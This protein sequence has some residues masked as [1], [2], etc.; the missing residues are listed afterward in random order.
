MKLIHECNLFVQF[1]VASESAVRFIF[2][3]PPW[4]EI[5]KE[6]VINF[7]SGNEKSHFH[8]SEQCPKSE[9]N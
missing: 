6:V 3:D 4:W 1:L 7:K 5:Q 8:F 2:W 9:K